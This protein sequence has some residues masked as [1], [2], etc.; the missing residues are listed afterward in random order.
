MVLLSATLLSGCSDEAEHDGVATS[1]VHLVLGA[2]GFQDVSGGEESPAADTRALPEGFITYNTMF[3]TAL[4]EYA[5]I[6][7]FFIPSEAPDAVV[8][9]VF[10]FSDTEGKRSWE[11]Q[12]SIKHNGDYYFYGF[13][14]KEEA[15][16]LSIAARGGDYANGAVLTINDIKAVTASDVSVVVG[17][18]LNDNNTDP[19]TSLDMDQRLGKFGFTPVLTT[20][21][22]YLLV[23]HLYC[24]V[25]FNMAIEDYYSQLRTIKVKKVTMKVALDDNPLKTVNATVTLGANTSLLNPLS[26][27]AGGS[28]SY[29][30]GQTGTPEAAVVYNCSLDSSNP[31]GVQL[32]TTAKSFRGCMI[33]GYNGT[34]ILETVYDVYDSKDNLI[35]EN[36]TAVNTFDAGHL[37]LKAGEQYTYTI[38][39]KPTYLY[40]LSEPDLDSPTFTL[41]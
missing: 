11:A 22:L 8:Q 4:P 7:G 33:P 20:N 23:D 28:I 13:M 14:P 25:R 35:R 41:N 31:D 12:V 9:H 17:V 18:L 36:D 3:S 29:A 26:A 30:P 39:V 16:T 24:S 15:G 5:Q 38:T 1:R 40:M 6:Q 21:Y 32:E 2:Q 37:S 10:T 27:D 19:I 34:C